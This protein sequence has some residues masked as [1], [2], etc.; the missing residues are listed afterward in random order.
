MSFWLIEP[1][2]L[3]PKVF[4]LTDFLNTITFYIT[5]IYL[6]MIVTKH[7]YLNHKIFIFLLLTITSI[8]LS[9]EYLQYM[10]KN[11]NNNKILDY[12]LKFD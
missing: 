7:K 12:D 9:Y 11:I 5:L 8:G 2:N 3:I 10:E 1:Q 4:N 6:F